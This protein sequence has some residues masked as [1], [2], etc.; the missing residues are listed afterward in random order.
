MSEHRPML[1]FP[2]PHAALTVLY[3]RPRSVQAGAP[4]LLGPSV[5]IKEVF[6]MKHLTRGES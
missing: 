3:L 1:H 5:V 2:S 6:S 4:V